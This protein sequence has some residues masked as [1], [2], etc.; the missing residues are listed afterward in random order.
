MDR[1]N[2]P[3]FIVGC[4]N[5]SGTNFLE[6]ILLQTNYFERPNGVNEDYLLHRADILSLYIKETIRHWNKDYEKLNKKDIDAFL[7]YFG[8]TWYQI[9]Q[10]RKTTQKK[11]ILK[12]PR[13]KNISFLNKM[14]PE[15]KVIFIIRDGRDLVESAAKTFTYAPHR[16]WMK[17]W[18]D[19]INC[20]YDYMDNSENKGRFYLVRYEDL[21]KNPQ[22]VLDNILKFLACEP[23]DIDFE[24]DIPIIGSSTN[25]GGREEVHWLPVKKTAD[26]KPLGRWHKW[27]NLRKIVFKLIA[28]KELIKSGYVTNNKW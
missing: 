4:M 11:I 6:R 21:Y 9:L 15:S 10:S 3:T 5:R 16:K 20:I 27:G 12:T 14:F 22:D 28:G 23:C 24:N 7:S 17:H 26:F 19:G 18:A 25:R 1:I 2:S 13:A 8:E